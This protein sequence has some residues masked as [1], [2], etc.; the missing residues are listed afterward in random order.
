MNSLLHGLLFSEPATVIGIL[1]TLFAALATLVGA[2]VTVVAT[3]I[4]AIGALLTWREHERQR[5][6]RREA[7]WI[8]DEDLH[9]SLGLVP[10]DESHPSAT[11]SLQGN[12]EELQR[13]DRAG[14]RLTRTLPRF[15]RNW[16]GGRS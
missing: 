6:Q 11:R 9:D 5:E 14:Q 2:L 13:R 7:G 16:T 8:P 4:S 15:M 12:P 3:L 10:G 1:A